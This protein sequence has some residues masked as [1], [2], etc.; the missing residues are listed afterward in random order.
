M[1]DA[2]TSPR[3][4]TRR[5]KYWIACRDFGAL[6][7]AGCTPNELVAAGCTPSALRA[8]G[9][10][11]NELVAA[12]FSLSELR[13]AGYTPNE[14]RAAGWQLS[15]ILAVG[16]PLSD[17][18][19]LDS[20]WSRRNIVASDPG[21]P[22]LDKPYTRL[23]EDIKAGRRKFSQS[24]WGPENSPTPEANLCDTPM[25]TAGS[26][27]SMAGEEGWKL[28]QKLGWV[29]AYV[30]LHER[31]HPGL[32]PQNTLGVSDDCALAYIEEM[33]AIEAKASSE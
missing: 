32:R 5:E 28:K 26:F 16:W 21:I 25:C 30:L 9:W 33:A 11:P 29:V 8:A 1:T 15:Q 22:K 31:A 24:T 4:L 14:L 12:G 27:V 10:P 3:T 23:L 7:A 2:T 18:L 17:I 19:L 13:A 6:R 20:D